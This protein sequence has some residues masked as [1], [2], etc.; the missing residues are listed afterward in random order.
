M[1][2]IAQAKLDREDSEGAVKTLRRLLEVDTAD[3]LHGKYLLLHTLL[4]QGELGH[5][6]ALLDDPLSGFKGVRIH[7]RR[8]DDYRP[9]FQWHAQSIGC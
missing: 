2:A 7:N 5:A 6:R 3:H 4:D 9:T 8:A 1:L